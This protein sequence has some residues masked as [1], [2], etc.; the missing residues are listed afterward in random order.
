LTIEYLSEK[1]I[2]KEFMMLGF[3][4]IEGINLKEYFQRFNTECKIDFKKE[5]LLLM[6]KELIHENN[7]CICL[8]RKGLDFAN[9]VFR[10]FV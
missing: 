8:K 7:N 10:E 5:L 3:R 1:T 4:K 6:E 9:Q 2:K